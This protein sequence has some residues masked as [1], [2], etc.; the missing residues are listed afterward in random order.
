MPAHA[1]PNRPIVPIGKIHTPAD[2]GMLIRSA[3]KAAG[4][5]LA[6][7]AGLAGVGV[8]FLS[9]LERGKPTAELGKALK[10]AETVGLELRAFRRGE[11]PEP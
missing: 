7:A 2:L 8:R 10:V 6:E 9:E 1:P 11:A 5:T 3:R 4:V